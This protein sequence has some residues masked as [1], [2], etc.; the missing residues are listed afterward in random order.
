MERHSFPLVSGESLETKWKL[1]L[2]AKFPQQEITQFYA[3]SVTAETYLELCQKSAMKV[4]EKI[5]HG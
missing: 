2:S 3:V 4:F 5:V 1:C